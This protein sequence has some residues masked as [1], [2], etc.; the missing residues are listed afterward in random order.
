MRTFIALEIPTEIKKEL[1]QIQKKLIASGLQATWVKP[2]N[3]HLTLAFLGSISLERVESINQVLTEITSQAKPIKLHFVEINAFPSPTKPRVIF[4]ELRGELSKLQ[5]LALK[6]RKGLTKEKVW[7]DPKPLKAHL[8][9]GRVKKPQNLTEA[10]RKTKVKQ[11]EF[12]AE[13]ITLTKSQLANSG[14]AYTSLF[15]HIF[16]SERA[17][18][19]R[20]S[21]L[22]F[23]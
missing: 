9:L 3:A 18:R 7:F 17:T 20:R 16:K 5:A 22:S 11:V 14:P 19:S 6:I 23:K 8:T 2:K 4:I 13:K 10:V 15:T 21:K 1:G 12:T